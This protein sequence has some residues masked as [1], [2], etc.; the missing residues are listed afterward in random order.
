M[1]K[2]I[3][4]LTN[5]GMQDSVKDWYDVVKEAVETALR[6]ELDGEF[7]SVTNSAG[8]NYDVFETAYN[9]E[10]L[11]TLNMLVSSENGVNSL[12][13]SFSELY[14]N[15]LDKSVYDFSTA[16]QELIAQEQTEAGAITGDIVEA[17]NNSDLNDG[18]TSYPKVMFIIQRFKE[19]TGYDYYDYAKVAKD[20]PSLG[21]LANLLNKYGKNAQ[22]TARLQTAWSKATDTLD[23]IV[24]N[25]GTPTES[26][27][28]FKTMDNQWVCAWDNLPST[29]QLLESL[30]SE[31]KQISISMSTDSF[32]DTSSTLHIESKADVVVPF[33]WWMGLVNHEHSY[34]L[35]KYASSS[36]SLTVD[37]TFNG[38][39]TVPVV[40]KAFDG[41]KCWYDEFI[42]NEI[43]TKSG[44]D[45]TGYQL[46][47]SEFDPEQVF[48]ENGT[49]KRLK[50]LVIATQPTIH[51]TFT[52]FDQTQMS[53]AFD[54]KTTAEMDFFGGLIHVNHQNEYSYSDYNYDENSKTLTVTIEPPKIGSSGTANKQTA[55]ILGGVAKT[56]PTSNI[57]QGKPLVLTE[58]E[59]ENCYVLYKEDGE[60]GYVF[61]GLCG[62][63]KDLTLPEKHIALPVGS[64]GLIEITY[65]AGFTFANVIG[66]AE[67][68]GKPEPCNSWKDLLDKHKVD[69]TKC[70]TDGAFYK[71]GGS[72][73]ARGCSRIMVGGHVIPGMQSKTMT[74][75]STVHLLPI[76]QSH[77]IGRC[78]D[79]YN[80]GAGY[81]MK[82]EDKGKGLKLTG[83]LKKSQVLKIQ[84]QL[85]QN[86]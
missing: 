79:R 42:L 83:Y 4:N 11:T 14:E 1:N 81:Y 72:E 44:S 17:Y 19:V 35:S 30:Q 49:L 16:D 86:K 60:D 59:N 62:N 55:F 69:I 15:I 27:G 36:S 51:L 73:V 61:A 66:S 85:K 56:Y 8:F 53:E 52:E 9:Q 10:S 70:C 54:E 26:N 76:C 45:A 25:V 43:A 12:G 32:S 29:S 50:T 6:S 57:L 28:A 23:A 46:K 37:V 22:N 20:F 33:V 5:E 65:G 18:S 21:T 2:N 40:P 41:E 63:P 13:G 64:T 38:V 80:P 48:G 58:E 47:G 82:T 31:T 75:D 71:P 78:V 67:D 7:I 3:K 77:N 68:K 74:I 84:N 24:S 34:D 39:T